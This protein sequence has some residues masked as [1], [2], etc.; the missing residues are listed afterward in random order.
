[1]D[2]GSKGRTPHV[3]VRLKA[4]GEGVL[5]T[6]SDFSC[7]FFCILSPNL[8]NVIGLVYDGLERLDIV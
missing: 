8:S 1:M 3:G 2:L 5:M 6:V 4:L 7:N